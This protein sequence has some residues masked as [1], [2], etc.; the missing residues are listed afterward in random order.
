MLEAYLSA[1]FQ[2]W[3]AAKNEGTLARLMAFE[4]VG[5]QWQLK[6]AQKIGTEVELTGPIIIQNSGTIEIGNQVIF[7]SKW[8]KPIYIQTFA[9]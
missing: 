8:Y 9:T 2:T 3:V 1:A 7:D 4:E 5:I 6:H